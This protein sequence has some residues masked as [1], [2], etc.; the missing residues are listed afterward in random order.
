MQE[1]LEANL[2]CH[3]RLHYKKDK[4]QKA[5][6]L[7]DSQFII[8][9]RDIL[10]PFLIFLIRTKVRYQIKTRNTC[11]YLLD[12]PV[13]FAANHSAFQDTPI[14]LRVTKRRSYI[15]GGLQR[16]PF[17]DWLFFVLNG[18][19]WVNRQ[20]REDMTA[21]KDALIGYLK[22]GQSILWF[23]EGT[24]NLT[25]NHLMLPMRWGIIDI[26]KQCDAQIIPVA[27]DYDR[28]GMICSVK[29]GEPMAGG[30]FENK[31][32]AIRNLRDM[33]ATLRWDLMSRKRLFATEKIE[34]A[35]DN[36]RDVSEEGNQRTRGRSF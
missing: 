24:W 25:E 7:I 19:V 1:T 14:M 27:L 4:R 30:D 22:K 32:E 9:I 15:F 11:T 12:K 10:Y 29:F 26:A 13:I 20:D 3:K 8:R 36:E 17:F 2:C 21:S 28:E 34:D 16:L 35:Y 18:T 5:K 6:T 23:P 33:L 31:A